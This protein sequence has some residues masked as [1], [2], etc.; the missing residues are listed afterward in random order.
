MDGT[1]LGIVAALRAGVPPEYG[2]E[3]YSVGRDDVLAAFRLDLDAVAGGASALR[4]I[5]ADIGQGKT[6]LLRLLRHEAFA[7]DFVVAEVELSAGRCPLY[8][9]LDVYR[10]IMLAL[11]TAASPH[12]P[13]L[14]TVMDRWLDFQKS[15][16]KE[17]R[18]RSLV[19]LP[20]DFQAALLS[21]LHATNF[22]RPSPERR[23]AVLRWLVG[24]ALPRSQRDPLE[25]FE[26]VSDS[27]ALALLDAVSDL[28][29]DIG[30]GGVC[31][32][33]DEA[34]A[35]VSFQRSSDRELAVRNLKRIVQ[36]AE[37][38]AGVYFVYATTPSFVDSYGSSGEFH[39][40][41]ADET[42]LKLR[43]LSRADSVVLAARLMGI[44]HEAYG[45]APPASLAAF[46]ESDLAGRHTSRISEFTRMA[47][48]ALD[49]SRDAAH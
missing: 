20:P 46:I 13:A 6:H 5:S 31:V 8:S 49:E 42:V 24:E 40:R 29:R 45:W 12:D 2:V 10:N 14:E 32:L 15:A 21:Y 19:R 9:L 44:Y 22:L 48:A 35:L 30:Y 27:N 38:S 11:R 26:N 34:E 39:A 17:V 1:A 37:E 33:F 7:R 18:E 25:L 4:Y 28:F 47:I 41:G 16:P 3:R 43:A 36:A 23:D